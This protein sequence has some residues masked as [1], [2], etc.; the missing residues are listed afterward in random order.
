MFNQN[1]RLNV[2]YEESLE[3]GKLN[4][5]CI[6]RMSIPNFV[7]NVF[8]NKLLWSFYP[9]SSGKWVCNRSRFKSLISYE[10]IETFILLYCTI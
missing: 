1:Y 4:T 2:E 7:L 10:I 6:L 3:I 5:N 8:Y 9:S